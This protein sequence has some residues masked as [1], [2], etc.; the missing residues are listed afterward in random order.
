MSQLQNPPTQT[1]M[2]CG[3]HFW[4]PTIWAKNFNNS[5]RISG[6]TLKPTNRQKNEFWKYFILW[7]RV[8]VSMRHI[9]ESWHYM[10]HCNI[11]EAY[12]EWCVINDSRTK[13]GSFGYFIIALRTALLLVNFSLR[14]NYVIFVTSFW[15]RH[16][17]KIDQFLY[18][19]NPFRDIVLTFEEIKGFHLLNI[20][21]LVTLLIFH[22]VT[23]QSSTITNQNTQKESLFGFSIYRLRQRYSR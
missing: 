8:S 22:Q 5:E 21:I 18:A 2:V 23:P 12:L 19:Q 9:S 10:S 7:I 11:T 6:K 3:R 13:A 1:K 15:W 20:R 17:Y 16:S 14:N 4:W